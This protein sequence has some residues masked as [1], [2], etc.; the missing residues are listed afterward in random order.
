[1]PNQVVHPVPWDASLASQQIHVCTRDHLKDQKL[2]THHHLSAATLL[3]LVVRSSRSWW[4]LDLTYQRNPQSL[5]RE[6]IGGSGTGVLLSQGTTSLT[7]GT[8]FPNSAPP[9]AQLSSQGREHLH[10]THLQPFFSPSQVGWLGMGGKVR[11][12]GDWADPNQEKSRS[13]SGHL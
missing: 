2:K 1:M 5:L 7:T 3:L 6:G 11:E 10:L 13:R 12:S 9:Q 8:E 4:H